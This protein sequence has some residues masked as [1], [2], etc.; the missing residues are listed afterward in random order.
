M[1]FTRSFTTREDY[2]GATIAY[3]RNICDTTPDTVNIAVSG[4]RPPRPIFDALSRDKTI[5]WERINLFQVDDRYVPFD[6]AESNYHLIS[7]LLTPTILKRLRAFYFFNT[8]LPI[9]EA[10]HEYEKNIV[11][12]QPFDLTIL[13]VGTDGHFASLFPGSPALGESTHL[14]AHTTVEH[15]PV[16]DRLTL[17]LPAIMGSKKILLLQGKDTEKIFDSTVYTTKMSDEFPVKKLLRHPNFT[18]HF[19]DILPKDYL[20]DLP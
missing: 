16:R 15:T 11:P 19:L 7:R 4:G 17:T 12:F 2:I 1:M 3:L 6:H 5:P 8:S 20:R 18:I 9:V 10:L 14:V 13:G